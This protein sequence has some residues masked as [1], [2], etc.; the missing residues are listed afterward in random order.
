MESSDQSP[1]PAPVSI[2]VS[3]ET[4]K[5][6][7][8]D[9]IETRLGGIE[10]VLRG[11]SSGHGHL[12]PSSV[13]YL[14]HTP[15]HV[16]S[17]GAGIGTAE[18]GS[19]DDDNAVERTSLHDVNPKIGEAL[20]SLRRLAQLQSLESISQGPRFPH[21]QRLPPGGLSQ[22]Q[23]PPL[24]T[25]V[26]LL[27]HV[28]ASPPGIFAF[29]CHFAG[30][31]DFD[32]LC[33]IVYFP[34]DH[35]PDSTFV[36]VNAGLYY[37]F[38][39]Q[40]AA[41][42]DKATKDE[43]EPF[44]HFCRV[45]LE[46]ALANM[47]LFMSAK[48]ETIQALFIGSVYAVDVSRPSV[49]WHLNS[50]AAQICQM[51]GFHRTEHHLR[52]PESSSVKASLFW[53]IYSLDKSLG[54]RLGRAPVI[55]DWDISILPKF[56]PRGLNGLE[57]A[58]VE[59]VWVKISHL[60]GRVYKKLYSPSASQQSPAER[61]QSAQLL[62]EEC[63]QLVA[64]ATELRDTVVASLEKI[65][66]SPLVHIHLKSDEVQ[67]MSIMTLIYR[68]VPAPE[69]LGSRFCDECLI[70]ARQAVLKH[71][72]CLEF[73]QEDAY[74]KAMYF[75]WSLVLTPFAPFFVLFCHIIESLSGDD[76]KILRDFSASI[77]LA[78]DSSEA[79]ERLWRLCQLMTNTASLYLEAK[80]QQ[81]DQNLGWVEDELD[82]YLIQLGFKQEEHS[83]VPVSTEGGILFPESSQ[84]AQMVDR[85]SAGWNLLE[86]LD[87]DVPQISG[88]G[89][90]RE[91]PDVA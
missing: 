73:I 77:E 70:T 53:H 30:I 80:S 89:W 72:S 58:G 87:H 31:N 19:S 76:L 11:L 59:M 62:A 39:E 79:M 2:V 71:L 40:H 55:Q 90:I 25:V 42:S 45:N 47:S 84:V 16:S 27:R 34:S 69:G 8:I 22:L 67:L 36:I 49:A 75:H 74:C 46:T 7:K 38:L 86:L 65:G 51:A 20:E 54:L 33:R 83:T 91:R 28:K 18:S 82:L 17:Y 43:F 50:T 57:T 44:I 14:P 37:L 52:H 3:D 13:P 15:Q 29:I 60:Q 24:D 63:R 23:M 88:N 4:A 32:A 81:R 56:S 10:T 1:D 68:T 64:E 12:T 85:V 61:I 26:S 48:L 6:A 5:R 9:L 35:F 41:A 21:Q 78:S 66:A